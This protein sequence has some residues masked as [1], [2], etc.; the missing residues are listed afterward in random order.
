MFKRILG[1]I[2]QKY[3]SYEFVSHFIPKRIRKDVDKIVRQFELRRSGTDEEKR[4]E[5]LRRHFDLDAKS[6][7]PKGYTDEAHEQSLK[8]LAAEP[9]FSSSPVN[10]AGNLGGKVN[11]NMSQRNFNH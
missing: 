8:D 5:N 6:Q 1:L 7:F 9:K 10:G 4:R 11:S 2:P 3:K